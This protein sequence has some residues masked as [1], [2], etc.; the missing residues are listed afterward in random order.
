[1]TQ[2]EK[3]T[4]QLLNTAQE[5]QA[6]LTNQITSIKEQLV[7]L[8]Q[9]RDSADQKAQDARRNLEAP[10]ELTRLT[11]EASTLRNLVSDTEADLN[12]A[13]QK[14]A[15]L[16]QSL[17]AL[18][19]DA[20]NAAWEGS[21]GDKHRA[22]VAAAATKLSD[23]ATTAAIQLIDAVE[24][25]NAEAIEHIGHPG[26]FAGPHVSV[27]DAI[28]AAWPK[29]SMRGGPSHPLHRFTLAVR[30]RIDTLRDAPISQLKQ[31]EID[32]APAR[33]EA[34]RQSNIRLLTRK[35]EENYAA[36]GTGVTARVTARDLQHWD[37][38]RQQIRDLGGEPPATPEG[39]MPIENAIRHEVNNP[40]TPPATRGAT[41]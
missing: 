29:L 32:E 21:V 31:Q 18:Q 24:A 33:A 40:R 36:A 16:E 10:E 3:D 15:Q 1:M 8:T 12:T 13:E 28:E 25:A 19:A 38:L 17:T 35:L 9:A 41:A 22:A 30:E 7:S 27:T 14:L 34:A 2:A 20:D 23:T 11:L 39:L 6:S 5:Q 26:P 37:N 4:H